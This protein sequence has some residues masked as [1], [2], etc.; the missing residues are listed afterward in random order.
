MAPSDILWGLFASGARWRHYRWLS[1]HQPPPSKGGGG[2]ADTLFKVVGATLIEWSES[3]KIS[4]T[5]S[6]GHTESISYKKTHCHRTQFWDKQGWIT[7]CSYGKTH[8]FAFIYVIFKVNAMF[9]WLALS[10]K[11][12]L[13]SFQ[14]GKETKNNKKWVSPIN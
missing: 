5:C 4:V 2:V 8:R 12:N 3:L 7:H 1:S 11:Q 10:P 13:S 14:G 9:E 6:V